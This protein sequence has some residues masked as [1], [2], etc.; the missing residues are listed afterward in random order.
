MSYVLFG[1]NG[2]GSS[3]LEALLTELGEPY[4]VSFID[5]AAGAH[6]EPAYTAVNPQRK[7]PTLVTPEGETLTESAAVLLTLLERHDDGRLL[8]AAGTPERAQA[9][10]WL[11]FSAGELYPM[12]EFIDYPERMAPDEASAPV[13]K[14]RADGLWKERWRVLDG[15]LGD[16]PFLL[17]EEFCA[18]DL[19]LGALSRWLERTWR[20]ENVPKVARLSDAVA[21]RPALEEIWPRHFPKG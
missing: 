18:V 3:I 7:I 12:V 8:P 9:L 13:V 14:D 6:R 20:V 5:G 15:E 16:G 10:R 21:A 1:V 4:E 19:H 11:F 17:G 2:T